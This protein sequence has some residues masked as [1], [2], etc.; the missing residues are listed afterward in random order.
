MATYSSQT[1]G[2][3][4]FLKR[5][6]AGM[7][8]L[9]L[10]TGIQNQDTVRIPIIKRQGDP[11]VT[12][13][14]PKAWWEQV[15]E[16]EKRVDE[17]ADDLETNPQIKT[18]SVTNAESKISGKPAKA[19]HVRVAG[20]EVPPV[21]RR[22]ANGLPLQVETQSKGPQATITSCDSAPPY[23]SGDSDP[24]KGGSELGRSANCWHGTANIVVE[25]NGAKRVMTA[26]HITDDQNGSCQDTDTEGTTI[27][28]ND[29]PLGQVRTTWKSLDT[30][31][32]DFSE[33]TRSAPFYG[34]IKNATGQVGGYYSKQ[35]LADGMSIN[36]RGC[37]TGAQSG[38]ITNYN[39][40]YDTCGEWRYSEFI[41]HDIQTD[42]GDSGGPLF[43]Y[44]RDWII[45]T[46]Q[47]Y[48]Y[49]NG[50]GIA[51]PSWKQARKGVEFY[52]Q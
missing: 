18:L 20:T 26:R 37:K 21:V 4:G 49:V 42:Y 17:M 52:W 8:G 39:G 14:V 2:R 1:D 13:E 33:G 24:V 7:S 40:Y 50:T 35:A 28:Q 3:R 6:A 38:S 36:S 16:V 41:E 43:G 9:S 11:I 29:E 5:S 27:Y 44:N 47:V 25:Y 23:Y 34:I 48:N 30:A 12:K 32:I 22:H 10:F 15:K 31:L 51:A 45:M 46:G 19:I